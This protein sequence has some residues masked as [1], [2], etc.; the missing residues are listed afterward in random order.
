MAVFWSQFTTRVSWWVIRSA[1]DESEKKVVSNTYSEVFQVYHLDSNILAQLCGSHVRCRQQ[2][3][4]IKKQ[5]LS[6]LEGK[7]LLVY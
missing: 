3:T 6:L 4:I 5:H 2:Q 1:T 7:V